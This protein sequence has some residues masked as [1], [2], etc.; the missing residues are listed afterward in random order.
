VDVVTG[1]FSFTGR[2]V[3]ARLLEEGHEVRALTR[4][5]QAE[6]PFGN[7]VE[8][9]PLDF[10]DRHGLAAALGGA[11]M[12]VNTY[13]IRFPDRLTTFETA[14]RRSEALFDAA[15]LAGVRRIV[16][17]SV[18]HAAH[19]SPYA[20]FR[21]KAAVEAALAQSGI[22]H[23]IVRPTLVFG[24]GEV[25]VNNIAWLLRRLPLFVLPGRG[26][27][28]QPVGAEDVAE[29]CLE[30]ARGQSGIV[31]DAAGPDV[32]ELEELVRHVQGAVGSRAA[33]LRSRPRVTI[34]LARA[35]GAI[36]RQTVLAREELAALG[37]DLL[38][39]DQPPRGT[40]RFTDWLAASAPHLGTRLASAERR[41]WPGRP[42]PT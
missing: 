26:Y 19:D 24:D 11:D 35:L 29:L 15:R 14:V 34:A 30:A 37:D 13:W 6:S 23:A 40:R 31:L 7:R 17:L 20:Y 12:L 1:A 3:A 10:A 5:P 39:S 21:G 32:F 2:Y 22:P 9:F 41:P 27:R 18:T 33:V 38:T 42:S 4:R 28:V 8:A 25:L 36:T 16:Q